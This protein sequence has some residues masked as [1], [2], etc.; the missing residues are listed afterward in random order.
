MG[1]YSGTS[2]EGECFGRCEE[3]R[4]SIPGA[5]LRAG[6]DSRVLSGEGSDVRPGLCCFHEI[7][8]PSQSIGGLQATCTKWLSQMHARKTD[9]AE[10]EREKGTG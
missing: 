3:T 9:P 10:S 8:I 5:R 2:S 4:A 1:M 7:S 6:D